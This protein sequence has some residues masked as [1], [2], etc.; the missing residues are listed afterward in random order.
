MPAKRKTKSSL[1]TSKVSSSSSSSNSSK[2]NSE[3]KTSRVDLSDKSIQALAQDPKNQV[4]KYDTV[5]DQRT[6]TCQYNQQDILS[7]YASLRAD[8]ERISKEYPLY[9]DFQCK[10]LVMK[11]PKNLNLEAFVTQFEKLSAFVFCK[12]N[13][14]KQVSDLL[15]SMKSALDAKNVQVE[16][17]SDNKIDVN[18]PHYE[19]AMNNQ[20]QHFIKS[21]FQK[22]LV[23][24]KPIDKPGDEN[25]KD[26]KDGKAN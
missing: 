14:N 20:N 21:L 12:T 2:T 24:M 18:H 6:F 22:G 5:V 23:S 1:K 9:T 3:P 17:T 13:T 11:L 7:R 4:Y 8:F 10:F 25:S 16:R 19:Q 26:G 15:T